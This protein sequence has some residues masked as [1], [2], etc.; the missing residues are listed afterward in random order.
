MPVGVVPTGTGLGMTTGLP[1][2]KIDEFDFVRARFGHSRNAEGVINGDSAGSCRSGERKQG[3]S[4][5]RI[6][7]AI[8]RE[9]GEAGD[10][11][12]RGSVVVD[13]AHREKARGGQRRHIESQLTGGRLRNRDRVPVELSGNLRKI[14]RAKK[15]AVNRQSAAG[16]STVCRLRQAIGRSGNQRRALSR[17]IDIEGAAARIRECRWSGRSEDCKC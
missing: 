4:A 14:G 16:R 10:S 12:C 7:R 3:R 1:P 13:D 17:D 5:R 2:V 11:G 6:A 8:V 9:N 15:S